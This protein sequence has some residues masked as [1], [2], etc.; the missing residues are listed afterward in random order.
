[1]AG[2]LL[3]LNRCKWIS[4]AHIVVVDTNNNGIDD[5]AVEDRK[6]T[7]N[8]KMLLKFPLVHQALTLKLLLL[9]TMIED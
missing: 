1:M 6:E 2:S 7:K 8:K 4:T 3:Y 9:L 5:N